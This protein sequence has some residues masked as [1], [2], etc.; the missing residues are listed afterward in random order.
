[1]EKKNPQ[2]KHR[3]ASSAKY[4]L[5]RLGGGKKKGGNIKR[6]K[7]FVGGEQRGGGLE[8]HASKAQQ[9]GNRKSHLRSKLRPPRKTKKIREMESS[10]ST[11]RSPGLL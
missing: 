6:K 11:D 5:P 3:N 4:S 9:E 10:N 2:S 1:L 8:T 7:A